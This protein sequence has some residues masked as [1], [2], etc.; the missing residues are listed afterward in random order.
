MSEAAVATTERPVVVDHVD[1]VEERVEDGDECVGN[2]QVH[3]EIVDDGAHALVR[4]N[5]PDDDSVSASCDDHDED[6]RDHVDKLEVPAERIL[7][8][9]AGGRCVVR[10]RV[11]G[12]RH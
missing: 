6:K 12:R 11:S 3:Q 4:H 8:R 2:G 9:V 5:Y 1:E 7:S 10:R